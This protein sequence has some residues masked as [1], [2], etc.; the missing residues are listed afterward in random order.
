MHNLTENKMHSALFRIAVMTLLVLILLSCD[1]QP[2]T[3]GHDFIPDMVY[4]RAYETYSQNPN[5]QDSM[6]MRMPVGRTVPTGIIPFRYTIDSLSRMKAG[7]ELANPFLP[8]DTIIEEGKLL[9]T[10]FCIGCHGVKGHGDGQL[11]TSGLYPLKPRDISGVP[12]S[13]LKDG[14]IYHTI[15]LGFGSMGPHG[16]QV[17]PDNRWKTVL[18]IRELQKMARDSIARTTK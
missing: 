16:A 7:N 6:T 3:R 2:G 9:F 5:F 12:T 15:T 17:K 13:E 18:Y 11:F 4:S 14:Q 1:R 10:K 8:T